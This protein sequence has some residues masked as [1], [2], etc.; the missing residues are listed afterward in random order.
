MKPDMSSPFISYVLEDE[1]ALMAHIL[2]DL[3]LAGIKNLISAAVSDLINVPLHVDDNS[4]GG[5]NKRA[6]TQ[7]QVEAYM[8]LI[9]LHN[10]CK[11]ELQIIQNQN[12]QAQGE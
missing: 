6:Y 4:E 7:G 1:E 5:K 8:H 9:E 11:A 12:S 10:S 3:Q 2:S